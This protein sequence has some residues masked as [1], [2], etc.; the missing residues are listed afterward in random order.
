MPR[1]QTCRPT[2]ALREQ[3]GQAG[4]ALGRQQHRFRREAGA[5]GEQQPQSHLA[6]DDEAALPPHEVALAHE[7]VGGEP[8]IVRIID[9]DRLEHAR[10]DFRSRI[11]LP[12]KPQRPFGTRLE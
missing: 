10:V 3:I 4:P 11:V 9:G 2:C 5:A 1:S 8:G 12:R 6:L 7:P